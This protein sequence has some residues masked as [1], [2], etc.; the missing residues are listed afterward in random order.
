MTEAPIF[1]SHPVF[2][3]V[4]VS[5][6]VPLST[7]VASSPYVIYDGYALLAGGTCDLYAARDL[8]TDQLLSPIATPDG[9]ALMAMWVVD[10]THA[11]LGPHKELQFSLFVTRGEQKVVT[12]HTLT[13]L[14][15]I[16]N[17]E[18][19]LLCRGLWN[20]TPRVIAYNR[21]HLGLPAAMATGNV[22]LDP[23]L[24]RTSF[25]F[26]DERGELLVRGRVKLDAATS[27]GMFAPMIESLGMQGLWR[28]FTQPYISA[29]VINPI[30]EWA[31]VH[32]AAATFAAATHNIVQA[33]DL[34]SDTI[35]IMAEPWSRLQ[36][37]PQ[38]LEHLHGFKFVYLDPVGG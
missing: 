1:T 6:E 20:D 18:A 33:Y 4:P 36:F 16:V 35:A 12:A 8:L 27:F 22:I 30:S 19:S 24:K 11:T 13:T 38:F 3:Q 23:L 34:H 25:E 21:E 29:T 2:Q 5:K 37:R 9:R 7:G 32:R 14:G 10:A 26:R 28:A 15:M 17:G 31:P